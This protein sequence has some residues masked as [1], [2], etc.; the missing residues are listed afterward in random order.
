MI[1]GNAGF[2][3]T[4]QEHAA[5]LAKTRRAMVARGVE[6]LLVSDPSNMAWL[7]GYDGWSFYVHQCVVVPPDGA[8]LW[9]GRGMDAA[10]A[11]RTVDARVM[12]HDHIIGY[13]D[14]YV[15]N[16]AQHPMEP[17]SALLRERGWAGAVIGV[18]MDNYYFSAAAYRALT[19]QLP[20]AE[21]VDATSLVNWQRAVKSAAEIDYMKRAAAIV[22]RMHRRAFELIEPGLRKNELVAEIYR[23]AIEGAGGHGGDYP[24]IV[25]LV[26]TGR[27]AGAPHLT[28]DDRPIPA[29]SGTFFEIAGVYKRY[30]CPLSRTIYLGAPPDEFLRAEAALQEGIAAGLAVAKPGN[31]C[32]DIALALFD[33]LARHGF[34]KDNRCGYAI[35]LSYPPDWGER[36]MSFRA[37]DET[38]LAPGMTFHFMPGLWLDDWGIEITE[39]L[40]ITESGCETL[41]DYPRELLVKRG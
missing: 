23:C 6:V 27:D 41:A 10:G 28:W 38:V 16:P 37:E 24:A 26:P 15:Q 20:D 29:N 34:E 1:Q 2:N 7:T 33:A 17:L 25:P 11:R 8:P 5:R 14:E 40:L 36:T 13:A 9:Y 31:R 19:E 18:E 12:P 30:H 22:E 3:F 32:R 35:G 39:S 21:W 4:P